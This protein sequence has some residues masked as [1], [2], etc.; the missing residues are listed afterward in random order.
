MVPCLP[1]AKALVCRGFVALRLRSWVIAQANGPQLDERGRFEGRPGPVSARIGG[2]ER[3]T[4]NNGWPAKRHDLRRPGVA[5]ASIFAPARRGPSAI[6][7]W[8]HGGTAPLPGPGVQP[9][10]N[11]TNRPARD[12]LAFRPVRFQELPSTSRTRPRPAPAPVR[13]RFRRSKHPPDN[14]PGLDARR[15][16]SRKHPTASRRCRRI[17]I[18]AR[19][20]IRRIRSECV[21]V[22]R[23]QNPCSVGVSGTWG[24]SQAALV[25][26][27]PGRRSRARRERPFRGSIGADF[28]PNRG[29][30]PGKR[31][32]RPAR[33]AARSAR[34]GSDAMCGLTHCP[35]SPKRRGPAREG[36]P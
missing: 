20:H 36:E 6:P 33:E 15:S 19:L 12:P 13:V 35:G 27:C 2:S 14:P 17:S 34:P 18:Q 32:Q 21:P 8:R 9:G 7:P 16:P 10:P 4:G 26:D 22:R 1:T 24:G 31:K 3:R 11:W 29:V 5:P 30:W 25:D 23:R 28:G